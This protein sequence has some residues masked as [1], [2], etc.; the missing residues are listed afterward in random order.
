MQNI[1]NFLLNNYK[2]VEEI[3]TEMQTM[4]TALQSG[5]S[6]ENTTYNEHLNAEC[7]YL[8]PLRKEPQ[9]HVFGCQYISLPLKFSQAE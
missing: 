2:Q 4:V 8:I 3:L 9:A 5:K 6:P 7:V 1:G